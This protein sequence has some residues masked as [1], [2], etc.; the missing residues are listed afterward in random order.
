M[1]IEWKAEYETGEEWIDDQHQ[2]LFVA[3]NRLGGMLAGKVYG[4]PKMDKLLAFLS[5]YI[6]TH[7]AY[8]EHCMNRHRCPVAEQNKSEHESLSLEVAQFA[9]A[10]ELQGGSETL[11]RNLH[12]MLEVWFASHICRVDI[13]LKNCIIRLS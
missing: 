11:V 13:H 12:T 5:E 8:E 6:D 9:A 7:F 3:I 4:G 2:Q 10:Y 1:S